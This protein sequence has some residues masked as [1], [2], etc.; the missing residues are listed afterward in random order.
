LYMVGLVCFQW[1]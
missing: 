1:L